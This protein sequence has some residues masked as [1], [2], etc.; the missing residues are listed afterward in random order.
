MPLLRTP[1]SCPST[2]EHLT[3]E[4]KNDP[5]VCPRVYNLP[6]CNWSQI[7]QRQASQDREMH[8]FICRLIISWHTKHS[9]L[10]NQFISEILLIHWSSNP[11]SDLC[12]TRPIVAPLAHTAFYFLRTMAQNSVKMRR[13]K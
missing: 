13:L 2:C 10:L 7:Q 4:L 8:L 9:N 5:K 11:A 12:E 3:L 6:N 1:A